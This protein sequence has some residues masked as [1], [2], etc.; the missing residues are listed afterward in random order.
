MVTFSEI[1]FRKQHKISENFRNFRKLIPSKISRHTVC[2][3]LQLLPI[4]IDR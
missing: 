2:G 4:I 3:T 1:N